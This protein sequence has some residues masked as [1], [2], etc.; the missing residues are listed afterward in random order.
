MKSGDAVILIAHGTVEDLDDLPEFLKNIRRGHAAPPELLAEVR[1]RYEAIGGRSPLNAINRDVAK[2]LENRLGVPVRTANR[3]FRPYPEAVVAELA[4]LGA[5]RI[6]VVPLAQHSAAIYGEAVKDAVKKAGLDLRVDAATNWGRTPELTEAFAR[7]V[8]S[9][10][11]EVSEPERTSILFTAHSLPVSVI[12]GGDPYETEVRASAEAVAERVRELAPG[13]FVDHGVAFQSQGMS[14]GPGGRPMAWLGPDLR[15]RLD[16]L[17]AAGRKEVVVAPIGFL[18]DHVE[19]LYDLDIEARSWAEELGI[20]LR[21][22]PSLNASDGLVAA[23]AS[24]ASG[25]AASHGDE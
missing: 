6:V 11:D 25:V 3:L 7:S 20:T 10:L 17:A 4:S 9:A 24:V 12:E 1:R 16:A 14:T 15:T 21:R 5:E 8:M 13:R 19:I 22:A 2:R 18:A 23:L